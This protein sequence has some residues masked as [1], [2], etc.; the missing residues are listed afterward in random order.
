M[1]SSARSTVPGVSTDSSTVQA[2]TGETQAGTDR[3]VRARKPS[4]EVLRGTASDGPG[5]LRAQVAAG[6]RSA[7][8]NVYREHREALEQ[9]KL[10]DPDDAIEHLRLELATDR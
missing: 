6:D 9:A 3:E 5:T 10:G 4:P 1:P 7:A 2:G 8:E